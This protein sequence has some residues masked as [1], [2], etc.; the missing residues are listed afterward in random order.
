MIARGGLG[1]GRVWSRP[2]GHFF[3]IYLFP[4][5]KNVPF[6]DLCRCEKKIKNWENLTLSIFSTWLSKLKLRLLCL[7]FTGLIWSAICNI[8]PD[9]DLNGHCYIKIAVWVYFYEFLEMGMFL[10]IVCGREVSNPYIHSWKVWWL[11]F[12]WDFVIVYSRFC[13]LFKHHRGMFA[14]DQTIS[15]AKNNPVDMTV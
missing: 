7:P 10:G 3:F 9:D 1:W 4:L 14:F 15:G 12:V 11:W 2:R 5:W 6:G 13:A 8:S